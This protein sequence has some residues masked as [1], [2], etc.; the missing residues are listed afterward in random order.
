MKTFFLSILI[1]I[2]LA[3]FGFVGFYSYTY[4]SDKNSLQFTPLDSPN[5]SASSTD[6]G[7][8]QASSTEASITSTIDV[9]AW[10]SYKSDELGLSIKYPADL[11]VN[12]GSNS[13]ILAFP[14][15][16]YFHWPL[17]D[18]A[19]ITIT[20]SSSCAIF[21]SG[22]NGEEIETD[23]TVNNQ[24]YS[25]KQSNDAAAGNVYNE[26]IYDQVKGV[27]LCYSLAFL[28]HGANGAGLY[29]DDASLIKKYDDQHTADLKAV[30]EVVYGILAN[31]RASA[32]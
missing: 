5:N 1:L 16:K 6:A 26:I 31:F 10:K 8:I 13:V 22:D 19:K 3:A 27:G 17:Q 4:L 18:D 9:S 30:M 7:N 20:A 14:K 15:T 28:D 11:I 29:V 23:L 25:V 12:G 24:K 2:V 21:Q 32:N